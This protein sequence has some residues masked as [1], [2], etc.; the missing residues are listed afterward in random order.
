M[1]SSSF[2]KNIYTIGADVET[3]SAQALVNGFSFASALAWLD[4]ARW[5]VSS[6]VKVPKTGGSYYVLSALLT[7]L[8]AVIAFM[9]VGE[10]VKVRR[11]RTMLAGAA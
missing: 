11:Q 5:V 2:N 6:V 1:D 9:I 4:V 8:V 10:F 3:Q 7:T